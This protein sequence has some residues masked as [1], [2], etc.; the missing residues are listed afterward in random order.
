MTGEWFLVMPVALGVALMEVV[1]GLVDDNLVVP[2]VT[3]VLLWV[4]LGSAAGAGPLP[5]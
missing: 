2:L 4:I 3:G 1:P 5:S